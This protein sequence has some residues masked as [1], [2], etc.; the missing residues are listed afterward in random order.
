MLQLWQDRRWVRVIR[1]RS[2]DHLDCFSVREDDLGAA[3]GTELVRSARQ[4]DH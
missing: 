4:V 1:C 3:D 2:G